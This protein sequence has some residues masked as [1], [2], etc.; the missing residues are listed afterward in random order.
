M[1]ILLS[2]G[3]DPFVTDNESKCAVSHALKQNGDI[4]ETIVKI[5]GKQ[6]DIT[7]ESILHYAA[8]ESDAQTVQKLLSMGLDRTVK[9]IAGETPYDTAIRWKHNESAAL[10]K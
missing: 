10:L 5:A 7:G 3:A 2:K 9:N 6:R 8:R 1:R 4:L